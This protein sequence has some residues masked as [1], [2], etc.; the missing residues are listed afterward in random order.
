MMVI[1]C[2]ISHNWSW[3]SDALTPWEATTGLS[4]SDNHSELFYRVTVASV[5]WN[6]PLCL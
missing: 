4:V 3:E 1:D 2:G 6:V 5:F